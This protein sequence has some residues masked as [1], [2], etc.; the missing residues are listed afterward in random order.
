MNK[1]KLLK[2]KI[3]RLDYPSGLL[4]LYLSQT[5]ILTAARYVLSRLGYEVGLFRNFTLSC[6]ASLPLILFFIGIPYIKSRK[7]FSFFLLYMII[8][9]T[10]LFTWFIH[11]EY[12]YYFTRMDYGIIRVFRPDC[13]IYAYLFFSLLDDPE[14][15]FKIFKVFAYMDFFFLLLVQLLPAISKGYWEDVNYLG[16]MVQRS[17]SLSFGYEMLLP[18]VLLLYF[19]IREKKG[20]T[21][22]LSLVGF[23]TILING[24]RGALVI[25]II[26]VVL[27]I[28]SNIIDS[29]DMSRK[30]IK[31]AG[32]I[33]LGIILAL[34][35][36]VLLS[37]SMDFLSSIDLESRTLQMLVSGDISN[38]TGRSLIWARVIYAIQ[39]SGLFGYGV[40]GDR[41]FVSP[42][43]YVGYSHNILL[44]L[45]ASFGVIGVIISIYLI[46]DSARMIFLCRDRR[47]RELFIIFFSI[48]CQ[49]L[50]SMSFW[51][52]FE[53]WAALA[54][55]CKY[56]Q[57]QK[58]KKKDEQK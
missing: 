22:V 40:Y 25:P 4:L 49:L 18:A 36:N 33:F 20:I 27:M 19:Y 28:I 14:D 58:I 3:R 29:K 45:V 53:F 50:I 11:P 57:L 16:K 7:Y 12:E 56:R 55:S 34:F 5:F 21:L 13:A 43:H 37:V 10:F 26:F 6:I 42:I 1:R 30:A 48:S 23:I 17:Y 2:V 24:S 8:A 31:I 52:V 38:D 9:V 41:P 51:Y 47:W 15:I 35:G 54:I 44:E 46:L 39:N 32:I